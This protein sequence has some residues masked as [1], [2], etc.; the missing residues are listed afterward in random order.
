[1]RNAVHSRWTKGFTLLE[2]IIAIAIIGIMIGAIAP[3]AHRQLVAA[4]EDATRQELERLRGALAAYYEDVGAFPGEGG[5]L[6]GLV[7]T[8]GPAGWQGPYLESGDDDPAAA[9][10]T[11]A[12][13]QD[14]VYDLAPSVTPAGA[15]DLIVA[16]PGANRR[17]ELRTG[18]TWQLGNASTVDDIVLAIATGPLD[19]D[20]RLASLAELEALAAGARR[21]YQDHSSF[22]AQLADLSG[23]Y[24]DPGFAGDS[25]ED[26]WRQAYAS[27]IES[28]GGGASRLILWSRGPN[29]TDENGGGD[30]LRLEV[31]SSAIP[32]LNPGG[33]NPTPPS[34]TELEL[35]TIQAAVDANPGLNLNRPWNQVRQ[36]L[37]L[38]NEYRRD[39]WNRNYLINVG[40]R[41]IFSAGADGD[42]WTVADNV[43]TG[44]GY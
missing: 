21:H 17:L 16:S 44:E 27:R 3:V 40:A 25:F 8:G 2:V 1:M 37:G 18:G 20:K 36:D 42:A 31:N 11:D 6:A 10:R 12:F 26:D 5:G 28:L 34:E 23:S 9:V 30:D 15:A 38:G 24:V 33:G 13:G 14:Y 32:P 29:H 39:E 43:P 19:R 41:R 4:R 35:Q 7:G 22:P